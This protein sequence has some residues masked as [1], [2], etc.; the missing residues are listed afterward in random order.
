M[1]PPPPAYPELSVTKI[2]DLVGQHDRTNLLCKL[3]EGQEW[4]R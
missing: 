4:V 3:S 2:L 1:K